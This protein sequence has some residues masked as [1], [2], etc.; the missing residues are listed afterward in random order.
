MSQKKGAKFYVV[1]EG[2]RPGIYTDW[3]SA[4][5]QVTGVAGAKFKGFASRAEAEAAFRSM[6]SNYVGQNTTAVQKTPGDLSGFGVDLQG[7]AVDAACSGV[8]GPM[9][10][11]GIDLSTGQELFHEGPFD[12]GTNNIGEF[13]ALVDA[14]RLLKEQGRIH[15]TIYSDSMTAL[16]WLRARQCRTK[17]D[18]TA[19]N[20]EIFVK[21]AAAESW[22]RSNGVANPVRK[23]DT[24]EWGE[25]PADFGRK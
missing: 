18:R 7:V 12:D 2:R 14:L 13:L 4:S 6:Y 16:S 21:I 25:I 9:E 17:L 11:R 8:P 20:S 5:E 10:Y 19:R 24:E 22:L 23:W 3:A 1:W 15:T